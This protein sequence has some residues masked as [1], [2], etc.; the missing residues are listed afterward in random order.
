MPLHTELWQLAHELGELQASTSFSIIFS[1]YLNSIVFFALNSL[2]VPKHVGVPLACVLVDGVP[3]RSH[4]LEHLFVY[5][6]S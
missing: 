1:P 2:A 6:L 3:D 5:K 4:N